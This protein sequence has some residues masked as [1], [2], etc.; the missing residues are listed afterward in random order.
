[1]GLSLWHLS[2]PARGSPKG[3]K[4][5]ML[6]FSS[7]SFCSGLGPLTVVVQGLSPWLG[8]QSWFL[9]GVK[10]FVAGRK[11]PVKFF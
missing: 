9:V 10:V 1:M 4:R 3:R 8:F 6:L 7:P 2:V 5:D 11:I